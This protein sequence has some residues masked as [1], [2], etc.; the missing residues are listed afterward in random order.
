MSEDGWV[1]VAYASESSR[2]E[3]CEEPWCDEHGKHYFECECVG[4]HQEDE[5]EYSERGGQLYARR[6]RDD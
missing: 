3:L 2:C 1:K 6:K 5:F 4:P